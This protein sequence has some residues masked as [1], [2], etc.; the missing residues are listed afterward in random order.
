[1]WSFQRWLTI[2]TA[3]GRRAVGAVRQH[4]AGEP[5]RLH[6]SCHTKSV[7]IDSRH[8][9][10]TSVGGGHEQRVGRRPSRWSICRSKRSQSHSSCLELGSR[11]RRLLPALPVA[12]GD[13]QRFVAHIG[14]GVVDDGRRRR[15]AARSTRTSRDSSVSPPCTSA[16]AH[17]R[18]V[19]R[20]PGLRAGPAST[21]PSSPSGPAMSRSVERE[22]VD[23]VRE[24]ADDGARVRQRA[25]PREVPG[26]RHTPEARL[27]PADAAPRGRAAG[28]CRRSRSRARA[29]TAPARRR[30]P[31]TR[32]RTTRPPASGSRG[33]RVGPCAGLSA[34][35]V[36]MPTTTAPAARMR[37]TAVASRFAPTVAV[38]GR[39]AGDG[40]ARDVD[41]VL[42]RDRYAFQRAVGPARDAFVGPSRLRERSLRI[43]RGDCAE[44]GAHGLESRDRIVCEIDR[45]NLA[46]CECRAGPRRRCR[47]RTRQAETGSPSRTTRYWRRSSSSGSAG[48]REPS[49]CGR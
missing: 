13:L 32:R 24:R 46:R 18:D 48:P 37:A 26:E 29:A 34:S 14:H 1:M 36:V 39:R 44:L 9:G 35:A 33:L 43:E 7:S 30:R 38:L 47:C 20:V 16:D 23:A 3:T 27:Q 15:R 6:G 4:D 12:A 21:P 8:G 45:R 10:A 17:A 40:P 22:V 11:E 19:D 2:W 42:D 28:C 49:A 41:P 5:V 25:E 31:R